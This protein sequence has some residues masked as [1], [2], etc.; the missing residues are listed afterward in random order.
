MR[1]ECHPCSTLRVWSGMLNRTY[2]THARN[3][4]INPSFWLGLDYSQGHTVIMYNHQWFT[5]GCTLLSLS[6][7]ERLDT[8]SRVQW[9]CR[10]FRLQLKDTNIPMERSRVVVMAQINYELRGGRPSFD[11]CRGVEFLS[12]FPTGGTRSIL[13][14]GVSQGLLRCRGT[15]RW[16]N[17]FLLDPR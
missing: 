10:P 7:R 17:D 2:A 9:P 8:W 16:A 3:G 4:E 14:A 13:N 1:R 5:A 11:S 6:L 12:P 15:E